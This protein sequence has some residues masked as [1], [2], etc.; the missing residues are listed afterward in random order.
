MWLLP[1]LCVDPAFEASKN[2]PL[3]VRRNGREVMGNRR[4]E[5]CIEDEIDDEL[6]NYC[7]E[8]DEEAMVWEG[9]R[10]RKAGEMKRS[11]GKNEAGLG[12]FGAKGEMRWERKSKGGNYGR[13]TRAKRDWLLLFF[14]YLFGFGL[15]LHPFGPSLQSSVFLHLFWRI[16]AWIIPYLYNKIKSN[17]NLEIIPVKYL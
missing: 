8:G 3:L 11:R 1:R 2:A 16:L 7:K 17:K 9:W 12:L 6:G 13:V 10:R 5:W 15:G 4:H 14:L